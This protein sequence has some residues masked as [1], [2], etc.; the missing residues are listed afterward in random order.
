MARAN[1]NGGYHTK[2]YRQMYVATGICMVVVII[3]IIALAALHSSLDPNDTSVDPNISRGENILPPE[4]STFSIYT[5]SDDTQ[6][7]DA[8]NYIE[9][10]VPN[11]EINSGALALVT[12]DG[13]EPNKT[14]LA[15]KDI[16]SNMGG[17]YGLTTTSLTLNSKA[18][19]ALNLFISSFKSEVGYGKDRLLIQD[20][21]SSFA[22]LT[23]KEKLT[24]YPDLA[25]G[26]SVRLG[27][28][29][30]GDYKLGEGKYIWLEDNAYRYGF[31]LRY[32]VGKEASTKIAASSM[33]YRY[34]GLAHSVY[35]KNNDISFDEYIAEVRTHDYKS[36][37]RVTYDNVTYK[38]YYA[39]ADTTASSTLIYV[40]SQYPYEISGD[41]AGGFIVTVTESAQPDG[42]DGLDASNVSDVSDTASN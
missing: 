20:A 23:S 5:I 22:E 6:N 41:N 13:K 29:N 18:I 38:I 39:E 21:Y 9:H 30:P 7:P 2:G 16:Y 17:G 8:E 37:I 11:T 24:S 34:V 10:S 32:P 15:L 31:I 1:K 36:P 42:I 3:I 25:S 33:C 19:D 28:T 14:L 40:P 4:D 12:A 35:I 26:Y 27:I